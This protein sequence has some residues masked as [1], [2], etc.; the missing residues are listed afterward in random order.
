MTEN[1][2]KKKDPVNSFPPKASDPGLPDCTPVPTDCFTSADLGYQI[3][4]CTFVGHSGVGGNL[5]PDLVWHGSWLI[6]SNNPD[7]V[8]QRLARVTLE[9]SPSPT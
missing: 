5:D 3:S 2:G 4:D 7:L 1:Q 8:S 9:T 6:L